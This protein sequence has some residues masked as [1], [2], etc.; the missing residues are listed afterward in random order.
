M[1]PGL[2]EFRQTSPSQ[3]SGPRRRFNGHFTWPTIIGWALTMPRDN[4]A[5]I[6]GCAL[7]PDRSGPAEVNFM[8]RKRY[9]VKGR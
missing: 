7:S 5:E 8:G 4:K 9:D 2:P 6:R 3:S 1:T